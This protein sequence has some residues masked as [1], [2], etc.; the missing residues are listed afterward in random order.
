MK[1]VLKNKP[2]F[3]L[4][5]TP[6]RR[7]CTPSPQWRAARRGRSIDQP[8]GN[9]PFALEPARQRRQLRAGCLHAYIRGPFITIPQPT[10]T[11]HRMEGNDSAVAQLMNVDF[12]PKPRTFM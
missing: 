9:G 1:Y 4:G 2:R 10:S 11:P 3:L 5:K 7:R 6:S 8:R 12:F